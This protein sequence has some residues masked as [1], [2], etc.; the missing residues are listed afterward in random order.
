[1]LEMVPV[2]GGSLVYHKGRGY[3]PHM[4]AQ[5]SLIWCATDQY[6]ASLG[7][8]RALCPRCAKSRLFFTT[9]SHGSRGPEF[10]TP[11]PLLVHQGFFV[12]V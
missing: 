8:H 2:V 4:G 5:F 11:Q 6:L 9:G 3:M 12:F 7:A 1:M 10:C